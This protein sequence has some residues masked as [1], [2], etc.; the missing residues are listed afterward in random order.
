MKDI[1]QDKLLEMGPNRDSWPMWPVL[2]LKNRTKKKGNIPQLGYV[3]DQCQP[4]GPIEVRDGNIFAPKSDDPILGTYW[5]W[6]AAI[7][8]GW[9]VD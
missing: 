2:P 4:D 8:D 5:S 1:A 3:I 6:Q 9:V 7:D